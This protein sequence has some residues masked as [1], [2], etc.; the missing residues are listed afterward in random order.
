MD[1]GKGQ[2]AVVAAMERPEFYPHPVERVVRVETHISQVFL[3]GPWAYKLKK[4]V[5]FGFLDFTTLAARRRFCLAELTL[6]RRLAPEIYHRVLAIQAGEDGRLRL[7]AEVGPAEQDGEE[8]EAVDYCLEMRQMAAE[9]MMDQLLDQGRVTPAMVEEIARVLAAFHARADHGPEVARWGAPEA[10]EE[11]VAENFSQTA[12]FQEVTLAPPRWQAI[13]DYSLGFLKERHEVFLQRLG[14]GRVRD[15]HGDLHSA[16][17]N[18]PAEGGVHIF[19]C[20]EFNQRFRCQDTASDLAFL[21]MDLDFHQRPD[22]AGRLVETYQKASGDETLAE[23]LDFYKCYRAVV[24][25]K[26]HGFMLDDQGRPVAHRRTDVSKARAYWRLAVRYAGGEPPYFLVVVFGQMGTGKSH[27][28]RRLAQATGWFR[29]SSDEMR[30]SLAGL[31][32]GREGRRWE[33]WGQG[34]YGPEA[35]RRTY[36]ALAEAASTLLEEGES[37]IVDASFGRAADRQRF[38]ELAQRL[39][40]VPVFVEVTAARAVV[41]ERL[42]RREAQGNGASDGRRELLD[43]QAAAWEDPGDWLE[44]WGLA[45][46]GGLPSQVKLWQLLDHLTAFGCEPIAPEREKA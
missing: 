2:E 6:N 4:P 14:Q 35:T 1:G 7:G 39:G 22:L 16:N 46:D 25:A 28:S 13:R 15:G 42:A 21:A 18:L 23:V 5:D 20:I 45:L 19:D 12:Q 24:R 44:R 34:F 26:V 37:V 31:P 17:I 29:V 3:T 36:D 11:N 40:A 30:K 38:W 43:A 9:R 41:E 32:A 8:A 10:I 27:L 33:D